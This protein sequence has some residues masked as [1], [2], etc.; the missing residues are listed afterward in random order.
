MQP[1]EAELTAGAGRLLDE[2]RRL[3]SVAVAFSGGVDSAL[4]LAAALRAL[5]PSRVLA[6]IAVSPSLAA[7]E[8]ADARRTAAELG[9]ELAEVGVNELADPG[10]RANSGDRCYFCKRTVLSEISAL[11]A[12]RG[13]AAVATGTH[14]DD[15]LSPHRPGLAAARQLAVV[16]PLAVAGF[17]KPMVRA[18]AAA[19]GL[20][21]AEKPAAPCLAS[22][23]S[24]GVPVTA[25]RLHTVERAEEAVRA[26]LDSRGVAVHDLRVRLL[27][28]GFR[29][30]LDPAAEH[31]V[32]SSG[33]LRA[34]LFE[35]LRSSGMTGSGDLAVY[36]AELPLAVAVL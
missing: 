25:A 26:V 15:H 10:Y 12:E 21:V 34:Q 2:C 32:R 36:R 24:V 1:S 23:I 16:E 33:P 31:T 14:A 28:D 8:L 27:A 4:V 11:A 13:L 17:G 18:L 5:P 20:R 30:E 29:L 3:G 19:W 6:T 35:R 9:A 22:R 7:G